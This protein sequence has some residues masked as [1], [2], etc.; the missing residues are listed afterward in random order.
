MR[1]RWGLSL[2]G[3]VA[4]GFGALTADP[5]HSKPKRHANRGMS[6]LFGV[7]A[8]GDSLTAE[9][10]N[11]G[12][13]SNAR[14]YIE[15]LAELR[16]VN[17]GMFV[18]MQP[19]DLRPGHEYNWGIGGQGVFRAGIDDLVDG[20]AGQIASGDVTLAVVNLA[21]IDLA[22][23]YGQIYSASLSGVELDD[24][25]NAIVVELISIVD[26]L[27]SAGDVRIVLG[28]CV[29][30]GVSFSVRNQAAF[31]D[32]DGRALFTQAALTLNDRIDDFADANGYPVLDFF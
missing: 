12:T 18:P 21:T 31:S 30:F 32:P 20:L 7:G 1:L 28:N 24:L 27:E 6:V 3:I 10:Q 15:Q 8:L 19:G 26:R 13:R 22:V 14:G 4:F 17:F 11:V 16:E 25:I 29:D 2:L 9:Q 5:G 23:R